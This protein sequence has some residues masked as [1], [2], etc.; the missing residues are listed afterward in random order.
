MAA[1]S[2]YGY[3]GARPRRRGFLARMFDAMVEAREREAERLVRNHLAS[4]D[5][6][7]LR[8]WGYDP[9]TLRWTGEDARRV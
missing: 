7:V 6:D 9:K 3:A 4:L 8:M 1:V 5:K 2:E